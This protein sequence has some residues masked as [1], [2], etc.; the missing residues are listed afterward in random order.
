MKKDNVEMICSIG[1]L[2]GLFQKSQNLEDF[3][4]TAVSVIAYHMN[5]AVCSIYML[6]EPSNEL[7]LRAN[8]GLSE[9]SVGQI[10][11]KSGEG[12]TGVALKE[13]RPICEG[14]AAR[15][16]HFKYFPGTRE[17]RY[18]S[19]LAVP[20]LHGLRRVGVLVVQDTQPDYFN[21][22]DINALRA[23]AAQLASTIENANLLISLRQARIRQPG[24]ESAGKAEGG[25]IKGQGA[26]QGVACGRAALIHRGHDTFITVENG[27]HATAAYTA[28]QFEESLRR[29]EAQLDQ[30]QQELEGRLMDFA[31]LI[32]SAQ[33]LILKDGHY[34]GRMREL[35]E[36]GTGVSEAIASVSNEYIKLFS[37]SANPRLQEKVQDVK[38]IG[39]RLIRNLQPDRTER[40]E[41]ERQIIVGQDILPSDVLKYAA[42]GAEGLV[43]IGGVGV[44]AHVA[45]LARSLEM[46]VVVL[47]AEYAEAIPADAEL[48]IDAGQGNVFVNPPDDVRLRYRPLCDLRGG[49]DAGESVADQTETSDGVRV[50]LLANIN[51][52]SDLVLAHRFK[53][54]G[55]GLYRSE[56]PFIIRTNFPS[57][58]EQC[59]IYHRILT[60]MP[61]KSVVFRTLDIGGDKM[62]DYFPHRS[63]ANPFLGLRALRF[64]LR[65]KDIFCQQLRALL[66]AGEGHELQIMFPLVASVDDFR[67]ARDLVQECIRQLAKEGIGHNPTPRLG[68]MVELPSVVEV[69]EELAREAQFISI[70]S[71]DLIQ[72]LLAVDRTNDQ[73]ADLYQ[74]AHPAVLRCVRRIVKAA[75]AQ[76]IPLSICG[77]MATAPALIP[78]LLGIGIRRLSMDPHAIPA[79]QRC[80]QGLNAESAR[81]YAERLL[82]CA[83]VREVR[84]CLEQGVQP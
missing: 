38:D 48:I 39:L 49:A 28:V 23:I 76:D 22:N 82:A 69:I 51:L 70:G 60:E 27:C 6:E 75:S 79:V 77:D 54:E 24:S 72:Y 36:Q 56:F 32:F 18:E 68:V 14:H 44:T 1:E 34:S 13:L 53:A 84:S 25:F 37:T 71:N 43:L 42:T 8:Q 5:A 30:L 83:T 46:P 67:E 65:Y 41:H 21:K 20:I 26:S 7:V 29:S 47:S 19:F 9:G 80:V 3:L 4:Q 62:L 16:P 2:A 17:E 15:N 50:H 35:I 10:R 73:I 64:S 12:L 31:S 74:P 40:S 33:L 66:R 78:F 11:M 61:G 45:I 63:E 81:V 57:E 55:V 59:P 52:V 58:E